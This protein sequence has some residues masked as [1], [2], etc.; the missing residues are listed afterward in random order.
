MMFSSDYKAIVKVQDIPL[1]NGGAGMWV[2][3]EV[4]CT[5]NRVTEV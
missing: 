5:C 1:A 3:R 2:L 4:T